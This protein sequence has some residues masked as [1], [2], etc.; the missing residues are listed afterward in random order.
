MEPCPT[1]THLKDFA[2]VSIRLQL[3]NLQEIHS[4]MSEELEN[5]IEA[6]NSIY[7]ADTLIYSNEPG[8]YILSISRHE[9]SLRVSFPP[10]YPTS[11]PHVLG[12]DSTGE[13]TR[14]GYGK[15]IC[16]NARD[17]LQRIF[18]PGSVC[19]FDLLQELDTSLI[20]GSSDQS[21]A[22]PSDQEQQTNNVLNTGTPLPP[23]LQEPPQ[24]SLSAPITEKKSTF[25]ARACTVTS[26]GHARACISHLLATDKRAS[27]ATHNITAY[28]IRT[29]ASASTNE[30]IYQD[31][32]DDG[33]TAAGGRLLH[34]LQRM[35]VWGLLVVVS[36]WYGGIKLGPDRF[37][38]INNIARE[39]V[40]EG[41]W[42]RSRIVKD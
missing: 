20:E 12:T 37:S 18:N 1:R 7:G 30:V 27:K 23:D 19:L 24:W 38:V 11:I 5:E 17:L 35:D 14:K 10:D 15:Y 28:R 3:E 16:D 25:L 33:E 9:T 34:L 2:S 39:A 21:P 8:V 42:T 41:G 26:P 22:S 31:Y 40:V 6:I 13:S 4:T 32:D 29:P 36:R